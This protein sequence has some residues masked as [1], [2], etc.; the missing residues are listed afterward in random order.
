MLFSTCLRSREARFSELGQARAQSNSAGAA[1]PEYSR[2]RRALSQI[3]TTKFQN[4]EKRAGVRCEGWGGRGYR[5]RRARLDDS[6]RDRKFG[7]GKNCIRAFGPQLYALREGIAASIERTV[8]DHLAHVGRQVGAAVVAVTALHVRRPTRRP[9][10]GLY[11][12]GHCRRSK[13][14][15][16]RQDRRFPQISREV[17]ASEVIHCRRCRA[18][19]R[20]CVHEIGGVD[21]AEAGGEIPA[22]AGLPS[23]Q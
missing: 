7:C 12:F 6:T 22:F 19:L 14:G 20:P 17:S 10:M 16:R 5:D 15:K 11:K 21:A 4:R 23:R 8:N 18:S 13:N 3:A 9:S 1:L 2:L